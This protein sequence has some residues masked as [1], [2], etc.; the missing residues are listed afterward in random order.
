MDKLDNS[1]PNEVEKKGDSAKLTTP[2]GLDRDGQLTNANIASREGDYFCPACGQELILRRGKIMSPHFAHK[3]KSE[4]SGETIKHQVANRRISDAIA[5]WKRG[6]TE[7][8]KIGVACQH[9]WC[10]ETKWMPM[11]EK[12]SEAF[13][14]L[15][16]GEY[17]VDVAMMNGETP[18]SAIEVKVSHS[19]DKTKR[20]EL[21][22]PFIEVEADAIIDDPTTIISI[23][24]TLKRH[25]CDKCK[26]TKAR[27]DEL[28][29]ALLKPTGLQT[30]PTKYY[31]YGLH[32]CW[33]CKTRILVFAWGNDEWS[34]KKPLVHPIPRTIQYRY[35]STVG[36]KYW[37]NVCHHCNSIQGDWFLR[38]EPEGVFFGNVVEFSDFDRDMACI[39]N[40][41]LEEGYY[42]C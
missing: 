13:L 19:V 24:D 9:D 10:N 27:Y 32:R 3:S 22:I 1:F 23:R 31:R 8:P 35:S 33:K 12:V 4:C 15:T 17:R 41:A 21:P 7:A 40:W 42:S 6:E 34:T 2:F 28:A 5:S 30:L 29:R 26:D 25:T 16:I 18:I 38:S 39:A 36:D 37:A 14:E 20:N 11:P